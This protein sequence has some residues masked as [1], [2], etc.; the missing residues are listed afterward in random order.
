[1]YDTRTLLRGKVFYVPNPI[2]FEFQHW[3]KLQNI[4]MALTELKYLK[5]VLTVKEGKIWA[6]NVLGEICLR[7]QTSEPSDPGMVLVLII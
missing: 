3:E 7:Q 1:M 2:P 5:E 4:K 6:K